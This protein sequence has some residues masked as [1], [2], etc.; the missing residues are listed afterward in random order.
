VLD[1]KTLEAAITRLNDALVHE[2][3]DDEALAW[4]HTARTL[5]TGAFAT[6]EGERALAED[7]TA[8]VLPKR[9]ARRLLEI[10]GQRSGSRLLVRVT[11]SPRLAP[12]PWELLVLPDGRRLVEVAEIAHDAP[13]VIHVDRGRLPMPWADVKDRSVLYVIDPELPAGSG[14][15]PV[16]GGV[17]D[18]GRKMLEDL[19]DVRMR[20]SRLLP[21]DR[22]RAVRHGQDRKSLG[23]RLRDEG[24][25]ISR[26]LY[27]GHASSLDHEPGSAAIHLHD[28]AQVFGYATAQH[29]HRPLSAFDLLVG[30]LPIDTVDPRVDGVMNRPIQDDRPGHD[31]WPMPTRVAVIACASGSDHR[32]VEAFGLVMALLNA[33]AELVTT[34]RWALPTDS[35]FRLVDASADHA[36]TARLAAEVDR[37]HEVNDPVAAIAEWQRD[38]LAAWNQS[39]HLRDTPLLW[40]SLTTHQAAAR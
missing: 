9:L 20:A 14:L 16:L 30:T 8:A 40:A 38:Q 5:T 1:R 3:N 4:T 7:L 17:G 36:P 26:L 34:T 19:L 13:A 37:C 21:R 31:I 28:D 29:N 33:G 35:S 6:R 32:N 39:G 18:T 2:A 23:D 10:G 12:V 27:F 24:R 11:P 25:P 15:R 22:R